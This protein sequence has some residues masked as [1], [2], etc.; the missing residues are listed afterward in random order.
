[1]SDENRRYPVL[2]DGVLRDGGEYNRERLSGWLHALAVAEV[3]GEAWMCGNGCGR[4]WA[5]PPKNHRCDDD[6]AE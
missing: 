1:M 5:S 2:V 3:Q 4:S 6:Q